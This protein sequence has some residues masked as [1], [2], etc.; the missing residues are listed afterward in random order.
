MVGLDS[1]LLALLI[2]IIA[3][4]SGACGYGRAR[5][6]SAALL[7]DRPARRWHPCTP[8]D[9]PC[10]RAAVPDR[11]P[12][13]P[14]APSVRPWVEVKSRRGAPKRRPTAGYAC[15]TPTSPYYGIADDGIHALI[16]YGHHGTHERI[17]DLCCQACGTKFS[18]R[19]GTVN[20]HDSWFWHKE[21]AVP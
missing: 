1:R 3:L 7:E 13:A 5:R 6:P 19:H 17:R 8:D 18:A 16:A 4:L 10:C 12:Q 21:G 20:D 9:C 11:G 14:A 2:F 15:P